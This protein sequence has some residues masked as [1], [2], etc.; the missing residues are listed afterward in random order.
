M[1]LAEKGDFRTFWFN[2]FSENK[3]LLQ[4]AIRLKTMNTTIPERVSALR[5]EMGNKGL[6]ACIIPTSDPHQSEYTAECWKFREYVSGFTGSAGT[7]VVGMDDAGL[8][9]DSRYFLQ[10]EVE[11]KGS[12]ITMYKSSLAETITP[13]AWIASKEY[14]A[15]GL[16]GAMF[17]MKEVQ[18]LTEFL[19]RNNI[20]VDA[21]FE[22]YEAAWPDR[23]E[24]PEG[25]IYLFPETYAGE[26]MESKL[27]RVRTELSKHDADAMPLAALDEIAW[28]FNLRGSDIEYNPV[29]VCFAF[30]GQT[31]ACLFTDPKKLADQTTIRLKAAG[32]TTAGY[33]ELPSHLQKLKGQRL[34]IDKSRINQ[35]ICS[36]IPAG[37]S[38]VEAVSPVARMKALKNETEIAGFRN[39]MIKD[40]I[41]LTRFWKELEEQLEQGSETITEWTISQRIAELRSQQGNYASDSFG[42][43]VSFKDHG[44][45]VHYEVSPESAYTV[46]KN[47]ILLADTGGQYYDGTTDITRTFSLYDETPDLYKKDY[48]SLLKGVIALSTAVFPAGTRGVQ[49]DVL[50]RQYIWKR[51]I[52]YLHGT[53][54][55][56]G[57]FL[58]VHEGP[59][60]VRMNENPVVL[61]AGM[62][63]TN[64]PAIY[65]TGEYGVRVENVMLVRKENT[66]EFGSYLCFEV[67]TLFPL[68]HKSIDSKLLSPDEKAWVNNYHKKVYQALSPKLT[69]EEVAWLKTKTK[70]IE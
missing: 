57:H 29:G 52:N 69:T 20:H 16:D 22:P 7:L 5:K 26:T 42:P 38:L 32:I 28:L 11:L 58:N 13:E 44:A 27:E 35:K 12:G 43:I 14:R 15:V 8:W 23:P 21:T 59:H 41:A 51:N 47:G 55:G 62:T 17:S 2:Y 50:A 25:E 9:V 60:S 34:L 30:V 64:E 48:T 33:D 10:A 3:L 4:K 24:F 63:L 65:R 56:V 18:Y 36:S 68:D 67:L 49:L 53:G 54:H 45:I 1:Q 66:T 70:I 19:N 6:S 61:E 31:T 39:A 37:S 40:G 46:S